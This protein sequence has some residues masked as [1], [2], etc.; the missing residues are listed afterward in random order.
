M[1]SVPLCSRHVGNSAVPVYAGVATSFPSDN[2]AAG[3]GATA[4]PGCASSI[5]TITATRA[6]SCCCLSAGSGP[7]GA[8]AA[9]PS[10]RHGSGICAAEEEE[11]EDSDDGWQVAGGAVGGAWRSGWRWCSR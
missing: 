11:G 8:A 9:V 7:P 4:W 10:G 5:S 6:L 2:N 3:G 1:T